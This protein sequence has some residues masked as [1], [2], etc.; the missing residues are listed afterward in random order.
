MLTL[1]LRIVA[2]EV[3][4]SQARGVT[5]S[6]ALGVNWAFSFLISRITPNML[7]T[8]GYGAF[9]LFGIMC[10]IMAVWAYAGLPETAGVAL[11]DV[12]LLFEHQVFVRALRDA[13]GGRIFLGGRRAPGVAEL[14]RAHVR[15]EVEESQEGKKTEEPSGPVEQVAFAA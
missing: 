2:G 3:A 10:V 4:P 14:K 12:R 5:L 1:V 6:I 7:S 8:L 13:P 11:E 9:L 15:D